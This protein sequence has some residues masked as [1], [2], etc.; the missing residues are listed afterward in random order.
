MTRS[1][2]TIEDVNARLKA[3]NVGVR[4]DQVGQ[5]LRLRATLPPKPGSG[6]DKPYQQQINLGIY[7]NPDGFEEAETR[8]RELGVM[9]ARGS[10]SWVESGLGGLCKD[11]IE[12]YQAY[13]LANRKGMTDRVWRQDFYNLGLK[14]LPPDQPL[15]PATVATAAQHYPPDSRA[16]QLSLGILRG[17]CS[18]AGLQIDLSPY[19]SSYSS[20]SVDVIAIPDHGHI[21]QAREALGSRP[22]WLWV[23]G[24]MAAYG[25]RPHECW[26][27]EGFTMADGIAV[28]SI[29]QET[30]TGARLIRPLPPDWVDGWDLVNGAPP[31]LKVD[32]AKDYGERTARHFKRCQV[33]FKPYALRHAYAIRGSA[34]YG[35]PVAIMAQ[36]M[37]HAP[38]VH[39]RTYNRWINADTAHQVYLAA[40]KRV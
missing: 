27:V 6:K 3:G 4:V 5:R 24:M 40:L 33:G 7:A 2:W 10:F 16:R 18:W 29:G 28:L 19:R 38:D 11:W 37:G 36:M 32:R 22:D 8:A 17:F 13:L 21:M 35:L 15:A 20:K 14:W 12:R 1:K 34:T 31:P 9:L 30:K 25:L 23:F 39:L 26:A